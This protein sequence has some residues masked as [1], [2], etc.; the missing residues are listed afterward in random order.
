VRAS[1]RLGVLETLR[2]T[3]AFVQIEQAKRFTNR[4]LPM[5]EAD[6]AAFE[7]TVALWE[8]MRIG[9]M[10]CFDAGSAGE[11]RTRARIGLICQRVLAYV[12]LKT[13]HYH[14]AYRQIP[15]REWRT[16]HTVYAKAEELD[17]ADEA[18]KDYLNRDVQ[19][20][21]P[22]I[23][24][25]RAV[26][27]ASANPNEL[28]QRQLTF[29]AYLLERWAPKVDIRKEPPT[30]S[31]VPA[32]LVDLDGDAEP[33]RAGTASAGSPSPSRPRYL[34]VR[35][36]AK[37]LRS[38]VGLLRQGESPARL[39]LGE[40]CVQ[41]SCEQLLIFLYRQWCAEQTQRAVPRRNATLDVQA[42]NDMAA[43]HFYI[44][45][46]VFRQPG[47]PTE[48][49]RKQRDEIATFGRVSTRDD[50]D[51][52]EAQSFML[53]HWQLVDQSAQGMRIVRRAGNPGKRYSHAQLVAVRPSDIKSFMLGQ[54]RWLACADGGDFSAGIKLMPGLPVPVAVRSAEGHAANEKY[55]QALSLTAAPSLKAPPSL[56][57]PLGW[58]RPGR[59][60]EVYVESAV[61]ARL[62]D[63]L[64]RGADHERVAYEV[65]SA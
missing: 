19:D 61:Q 12:G 13:F 1:I 16:L 51:Y 9:Y 44:S 7:K 4:A 22:R 39:A 45:G 14:R 56:V 47:E 11:V 54:V 42:C 57:L 26:L 33:V 49:S 25:L 23:A 53:E 64:E 55:V 62:T 30:D 17:V 18:V 52:S 41:P 37:S 36:L 15:A 20:T 58:F 38:R 5:A 28:T 48:L 29:V 63:L 65:I 40:D 27:M 24:Y 35:R 10:R 59:V 31:D 34:D 60:I 32:M 46:K 21:S 6:S 43:I 8:Q 50:E 3:V 2:E